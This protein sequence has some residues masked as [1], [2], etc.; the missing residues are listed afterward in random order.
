FRDP[1]AYEHASPV[2]LVP[3]EGRVV[4]ATRS[5]LAV[6]ARGADGKWRVTGGAKPAAPLAG[7]AVSTD[8]K[9]LFT[10]IPDPRTGQGAVRLLTAAM[11]LE[12]DEFKPKWMTS[13]GGEVNPSEET[14]ST[15]PPLLDG[16]RLYAPVAFVAGPY[17]PALEC[18]DAVTGERLWLTPLAEASQQAFSASTRLSSSPPAMAGGLVLVAPSLGFVAALDPATGDPEWLHVYNSSRGVVDGWADSP[19]RSIGSLALFA[20]LDAEDALRLDLN[21]GHPAPPVG[22]AAFPPLRYTLAD[23]PRVVLVG[24]D[25]A[26]SGEGGPR[27]L[28]KVLNPFGARDVLFELP[29]P[30]VARPAAWGG[31]LTVPTSRGLVTLDL[32]SG[33]LKVL[34][35]WKP[36]DAG[37]LVRIPGWL[38]VVRNGELRF[39]E[40]KD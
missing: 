34:L 23:G 14:W 4:A 6:I 25:G 21:T 31:I 3:F 30:P 19:P 15:G 7:A 28:V 33:E 18:L 17:E 13:P 5:G 38:V 11:T 16:G 24:S 10:V 2:R 29:D 35:E 8:G 40:A 27:G 39:W 22:P 32:E 1:G 26:L 20:P 37:D 36:E 12:G 9:R